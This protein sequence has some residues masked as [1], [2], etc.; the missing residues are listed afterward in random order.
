MAAMP[1]GDWFEI[2]I[3]ATVALAGAVGGLFIGVWRWGRSSALAEQSV[4]TQFA[5]LREEVRDEMATHIQKI[6]DGHDGLVSHFEESFNG[7]RRQHDDHKLDVEKR[8][9]LKDDFKDFR[10]EY[11]EDMR[12]IKTAIANIARQQ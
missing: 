6:T 7:M 8:F 2:A 3:K 1:S 11:R 9:M 12:D 4:A 10:D 5:K